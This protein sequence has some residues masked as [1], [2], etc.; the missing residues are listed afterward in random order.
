MWRGVG[1][2]VITVENSPVLSGSH[3][4]EKTADVPGQRH[5]GLHLGY[6][7]EGVKRI[8]KVVR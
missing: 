7:W 2:G 6:R 8:G 5:Q 3:E 4:F 1:V